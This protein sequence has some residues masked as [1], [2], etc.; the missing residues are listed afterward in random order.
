MLVIA[1]ICHLVD[2]PICRIT[3]VREAPSQDMEEG[4]DC[5][6]VELPSAD[7]KEILALNALA[8]HEATNVYEATSIGDMVDMAEQYRKT[9]QAGTWAETQ[10]ALELTLG[11]TKRTFVY[12]SVVAA[13]TLSP[14]AL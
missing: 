11:S 8:H 10:K 6:V 9:T 4:M 12:R 13:Q 14:L 2:H 7:F 5:Q 3:W 1:L